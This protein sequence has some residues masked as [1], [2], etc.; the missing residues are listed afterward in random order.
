MKVLIVFGIIAIVIGCLW[1]GQGTGYIMWPRS[2]FMLQQKQWAYYGA[3]LA[4]V[5]VAILIYARSRHA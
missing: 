2:S 5:G 1:I 3:V 4:I